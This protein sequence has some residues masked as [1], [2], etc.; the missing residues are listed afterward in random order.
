MRCQVSLICWHNSSRLIRSFY[1]VIYTIIVAFYFLHSIYHHSFSS[2]SLRIYCLIF[3]C[4]SYYFRIEGC[5]HDRGFVVNTDTILCYIF[6]HIC[7]LYYTILYSTILYYTIL[8]YSLFFVVVIFNS[9]MYNESYEWH[10]IQWLQRCINGVRTEGHMKIFHC[11]RCPQIGLSG[12]FS[13]PTKMA[14]TIPHRLTASPPH[15]IPL[16]RDCWSFNHWNYWN[17]GHGHY[18]V[19]M[20]PIISWHW[21][22]L[23]S[24]NRIV[25]QSIEVEK[26]RNAGVK[27]AGAFCW[28]IQHRY[29]LLEGERT[30]ALSCL[31]VEVHFMTVN[32]SEYYSWSIFNN[33]NN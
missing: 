8:L 27:S 14:P 23:C 25:H 7:L 19:M 33:N 1:S 12:S 11:M 2:V 6:V 26:V 13:R 5:Y 32:R 21:C 30:G 24:S 15:R 17:D 3:Q 4:H 16:Q 10:L 31:G 28:H 29:I 9:I 20:M 22:E 18:Q